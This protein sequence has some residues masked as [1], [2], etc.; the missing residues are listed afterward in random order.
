MRKRRFVHVNNLI[1][2]IIAAEG[3]CNILDIGGS[4]YYWEDNMDFLSLFSDAI[5]ITVANLDAQ[6]VDF[7]DTKLFTF[8]QGNACDESLYEGK[9]NL[10]HSNS[11]IEHVGMENMQKLSDL[12]RRRNIPY[13]VQTPNYWFPVEPHFRFIG[14]QW[15]PVSWRARILAKR[16]MGLRVANSLE[17]ALKSVNSIN[18][19]KRSQISK[20]FPDAQIFNEK[21]GPFTKSFMVIGCCEWG[22]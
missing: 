4:E 12:I 11:L 13:Y 5:T 9:Y 2:S 14:F 15:L 22:D 21:V 20:Y 3:F 8:K 7:K 17:D 16:R 18:L 1:K 6:E 10:I 19:L